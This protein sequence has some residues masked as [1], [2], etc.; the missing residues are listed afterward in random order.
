MKT[1][2]CS[3]CQHPVLFESER[4]EGCGAM[5]GFIPESAK[6]SAFQD[7][8]DGTWQ[9]LPDNG[10]AL[11]RPCVNYATQGI[12]N[13]M[14]PAHSRDALC[15][16]CRL[17]HMIPNLAIPHRRYY[18]FM[19]EAAKRRLL[20][21]LAD[22][23]LTV[24]S[25]HENPSTGLQFAF[26]EDTRTKPVMTGHA[27]GLITMNVAEANDAHRE[28]VR[29][30][31]GEP[32]RTLLGH[33]RHETGHYFFDR[34]VARTSMLAE[35]RQTFGD[36]RADYSEA[37]AI[38][39]RDGATREWRGSF[40]SAYATMH[41]WEDWAETWAHYLRMVDTIDT[42][43]ACGVAIL[44]DDP[45]SSAEPAS[46]LN[47][48]ADFQLSMKRWFALTNTVNSLNRSLGVPDS[49]PIAFSAKVVGKLRFVDRIV[50]AAARG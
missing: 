16:A 1:F 30:A 19:L 20:Y 3:H 32:H 4:C 37:L 43:I 34:L 7:V 10:T 11:Y 2:H 31:M 8:G 15:H 33:F 44:P 49:Y 21:T 14:I 38:H 48:D 29:L 36:E 24:Q 50:K 6:M 12:C 40:V 45:P 27:N 26:L 5:L 41:P 22:L 17:T 18:W 42:A 9:R 13:W 47:D 46:S 35:F 39:Y 28:R 25:R 23:G